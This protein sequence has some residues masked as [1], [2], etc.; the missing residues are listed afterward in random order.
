MSE[1]RRTKLLPWA[2]SLAAILLLAPRSSVS[3][4]PDPVRK[5]AAAKLKAVAKETTAVAKCHQTAILKGLA[6][7]DACLAKAESKL[8]EAIQ[9]ADEDGACAGTASALAA[10]ADGCVAASLAEV[11]PVTTTT[12]LAST[13]TSLPP[14]GCCAFP[15]AQ[16][17]RWIAQ[18]ACEQA[19]GTPYP[20]GFACDGGTGGCIPPG[21]PATAGNCCT[22]VD[23]TTGRRICFAGPGVTVSECGALFP[24]V[25]GTLSTGVCPPPD[26]NG[27]SACVP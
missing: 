16:A 6:V 21:T 12:T 17:C 24:D 23:A 19:G 25:V 11:Q 7:D 3:T 22:R 2:A 18:S 14:Q 8:A 15:V 27:E 1:E 20:D 4:P 13:T 26:A 5:C 9:K 10:V